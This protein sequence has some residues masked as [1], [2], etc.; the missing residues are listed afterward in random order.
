MLVIAWIALVLLGLVA[1]V[2]TLHLIVS[3][4]NTFT[5][6]LPVPTPRGAISQIVDA[7]D[8]PEHGLFVEPGCGDGRILRA[9][10]D[11]RPELLTVGIENNPVSLGVARIR[12]RGRAKLVQ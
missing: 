4:I 7:L 1:M 11:L 12:L 9:I 5:S 10:V 6:A 3:G 2:I 8:L